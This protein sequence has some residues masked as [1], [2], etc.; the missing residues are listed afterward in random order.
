VRD[1]IRVSEL[2]RQIR[3][4]QKKQVAV[5]VIVLL[6]L[7]L[8]S[9]VLNFILMDGRASQV[10]KLVSRMSQTGDFREVVLTLQ[11]ARLQDFKSIT[12][13]SENARKT[14]SLPTSEQFRSARTFLD[15]LIYPEIRHDLESIDTGA[16][17]DSIKFEYGRFALFP[18][19]VLIWIALN[20][21]AI[22]QTVFMRRRIEQQYQ[23]DLNLRQEAAY[24]EIARKV[25]HNIRTPLA[26]LM[27]LSDSL[28]G[29]TVD[30]KRL[31]EGIIGQIKDLV[32]DLDRAKA[33]GGPEVALYSI[34]DTVSEAFREARLTLRN[35]IEFKSSVDDG[36]NSALVRFIPHEMKAMIAN[37]VNNA[38]DAIAGAGEIKAMAIDHIDRIEIRVTDTGKGISPEILKRVGEKGLTVGKINGTGIGL[39]HA[40]SVI[41]SW[42]GD[43]VITS[44]PGQT[45]VSIFLPIEARAAWYT[46]RLKFERDD[47]VVIVD[48][49]ISIHR[50]WAMRLVEAGFSGDVEYHFD[51]PSVNTSVEDRVANRPTHFFVDYDLGPESAES[52]LDFLSR[53][54]VA[55]RYL[56]TGHFDDSNVQRTCVNQGIILVPKTELVQIPIVVS[57]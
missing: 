7:L 41:E 30:E 9:I 36:L 44:S 33:D 46:P 35:G 1:G 20:L 22:P 17:R 49:Q 34:S 53:L 25:R 51:L 48:D 32:L 29:G 8:G 43:L 45:E 42:N 54:N 57:G 12:Y 21:F 39:Y 2:R 16:S 11:D 15:A 4:F 47:R 10:T 14:F 55:N 56:V 18:Y 3:D 24:G 5:S 28:K 19:A 26:A 50:L 40:K 37:L 23:R 38:A 6:C 27:R 52:G 31:F 13:L